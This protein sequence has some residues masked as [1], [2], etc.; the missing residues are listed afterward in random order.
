MNHE[1]FLQV[2]TKIAK[3]I[4]EKKL[5]KEEEEKEK[6]FEEEKLKVARIKAGEAIRPYLIAYKDVI[7][8]LFGQGY[9]QDINNCPLDLIER[10]ESIK[11]IIEKKAKN[12]SKKAINNNQLEVEPKTFV[13]RIY[14]FSFFLSIFC[15]TSSYFPYASLEIDPDSKLT[16]EGKSVINIWKKHPDYDLLFIWKSIEKPNYDT[17]ISISS[18]EDYQIPNPKITEAN[19]S[20]TILNFNA[21]ATALIEYEKKLP[22]KIHKISIKPLVA[23]R[24]CYFTDDENHHVEVFRNIVIPQP[25]TND[26]LQNL[27]K[28]Y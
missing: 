3:E 8:L 18:Q 28:F 22:V 2:I 10:L 25:V 24:L 20:E 11:S 14:Y 19:P 16:P 5:K 9:S 23:T 6:S 13:D 26:P 1:N 21:Y 27:L 15:V 17:E 7:D 12:S 4:E